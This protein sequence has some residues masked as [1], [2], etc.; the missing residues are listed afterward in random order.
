MADTLRVE[1]NREGLYDVATPT[2]FETDDTFTLRLHNGGEATHVHVRL[3]DALAGVL[4]VDEVN[5]YVE[6]DTTRDITVRANPDRTGDA[7]G[8]L[9]VAV[10]HGA[11]KATTELTLLEPGATDVALDETLAAPGESKDTT[12]SE[13]LRPA[14]LAALAVLLLAGGLVASGAF[15]LFLGALALLAA[16]LAARSL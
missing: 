11:T 13:D 2:R 4:A 8:R 3:S 15:G 7:R 5:H 16:G 6:A 14:L 9:E 12:T 1:L 10:G